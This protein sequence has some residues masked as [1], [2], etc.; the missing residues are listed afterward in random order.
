MS[1]V[2]FFADHCVSNLVV[3]ELRNAGHEVFQLKDHI[4]T[5]S[6]DI[7]VISKAQELDSTLVSLNGDFTDIVNYP[8]A[9]FKGILALQVKN[10]PEVIP[11]LMAR[12]KDYLIAHPDVNH[13]KGKLLLVE[14]HR[15]RVRE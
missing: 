12:L 15:I 14:V 7:D 6:S 5:D 1:K 3:R 4:P 9:K 2:R 11:Q 10:H 8:P 13:Y